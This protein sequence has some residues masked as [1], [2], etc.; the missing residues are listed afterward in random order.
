MKT[1][2]ERVKVSI[3]DAV[4]P[5]EILP[6]REAFIV[7][8]KRIAYILGATEQK[9]I[10]EQVRLKKCDDMTQEECNREAA[11][12]GWYRENRKGTPT[13]SDAIEWARK[14]LL[15]EVCAVLSELGVFDWLAE[16]VPEG[17]S[18]EVHKDQFR[19]CFID[20]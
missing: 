1:I 18:P 5:D 6:A 12:A 15:D 4:N 20:E 19:K 8:Q 16:D 10:D 7:E 13:Y 11:F 9:V 17:F 14:N 2:E 3:P